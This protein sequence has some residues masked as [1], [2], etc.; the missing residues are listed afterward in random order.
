MSFC[1]CWVQIKVC[2]LGQQYI[3]MSG[4]TYFGFVKKYLKLTSVEHFKVR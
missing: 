2:E 4:K 3:Y 1:A